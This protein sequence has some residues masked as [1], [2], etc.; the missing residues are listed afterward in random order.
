MEKAKLQKAAE[1]ESKTCGAHESQSADTVGSTALKNT[2]TTAVSGGGSCPPTDEPAAAKHPQLRKR[3]C[4]VAADKTIDINS[5]Q[6]SRCEE[7]DKTP[8]STT[9]E[10]ARVEIPAA[11]D[12]EEERKLEEIEKGYALSLR[13]RASIVAVSVAR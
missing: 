8:S 6:E 10:K 5:A 7:L 4:N 2:V 9:S 11:T 3:G 12:R 1:Q 13:S